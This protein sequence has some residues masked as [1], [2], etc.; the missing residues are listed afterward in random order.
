MLNKIWKNLYKIKNKLKKSEEEEIKN[1][2]NI[3]YILKKVFIYLIV[4]IIIIV[5]FIIFF[6]KKK[7]KKAPPHM[8]D[9]DIEEHFDKATKAALKYK[10]PSQRN[11]A[12]NNIKIRFGLKPLKI[13]NVSTVFL[14]IK[15]DPNIVIKRALIKGPTQ[16]DVISIKLKHNN[17]LKTYEYYYTET[18]D[19]EEYLWLISEFM[20]ITVKSSL[21]NRS[22]T[23][24]RKVI[25]DILKG[26]SYMHDRNIAHLDLKIA[27]IMGKTEKNGDVTYKIIDFGFSRDLNLLKGKPDMVMIPGKSYG[28]Y[29]YKPTEVVYNN[30]HGLKSDI[31]CIGA[32]C[33]FLIEGRTPFYDDTGNKDKKLWHKFLNNPAVI[34][35]SDIS[36]ELYDFIDKCLQ[37]DPK[38]RPSAKE[39]LNSNFIKNIKLP[40]DYIRRTQPGNFSDQSI[41]SESSSSEEV[42]K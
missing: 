21:I 13:N 7:Y 11:Q 37:F 12:F 39:L 24:L 31:W 6:N 25:T 27:N 15:T 42:D 36:N 26:L 14:Q 9:S 22:E 19:G 1:K 32:I 38:N 41:D 30:E 5:S 10:K 2:E 4:L 35:P 18:D 34:L 33:W 20:D 3:K 8:I 28:T 17:L 23:I 16:E 40:S 29:P